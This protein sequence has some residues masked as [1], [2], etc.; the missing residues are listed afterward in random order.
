MKSL[1]VEEAGA[2]ESVNRRAKKKSTVQPGVQSRRFWS[3]KLVEI[4]HDSKGKGLG[5][6]SNHQK[7]RKSQ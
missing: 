3:Q 4:E 5:G 7:Q 2:A 1:V 6:A